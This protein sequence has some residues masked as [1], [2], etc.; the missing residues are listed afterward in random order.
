VVWRWCVAVVCGGGVWRVAIVVGWG[1]CGGVVGVV[2]GWGWG[3]WWGGGGYP[4][5][6]SISSSN[7]HC[8]SARCSSQAVTVAS[9]NTQVQ[10]GERLALAQSSASRSVECEGYR[11]GAAE[12]PAGELGSP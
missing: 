5:G 6:V 7:E 9:S 1:E 8:Q 11:R 2:G 12:I 3:W 4:V 10:R